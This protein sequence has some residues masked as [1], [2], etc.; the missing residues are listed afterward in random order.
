MKHLSIRLKIT[1]WFTAFLVF[2]VALTYAGILSVSN[3]VI[4]KTIRDSLIETV[5]HNVDEIEY[6]RSIDDVDLANDVDH[7]IAYAGGYLEVDDDFLDAVNQVYTALYSSDQ[8]LLYGENPIAGE[9]FARGLAD[10]RI[11]KITVGGTGYYI[12]DRALDRAGLEGLWL[13]GVVSE[14]QGKAEMS[15]ISRLSLILLP[16][17]V[18]IAAVG[19]YLLAKRM[20][21]PVQ[22]IS[23]AAAQIGERGDLKKRIE[24]GDGAVGPNG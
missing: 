3:Q 1:L 5:E 6:Y 23:D 4:Q 16:T 9:S 22:Q 7:F 19:G 12:F 17:L 10:S 20:L 2:V 21:R 11:Q 18:L 14:A 24:L 13:R 15:A 8:T